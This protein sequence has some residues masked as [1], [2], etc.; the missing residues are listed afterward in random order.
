[1]IATPTES[2]KAPNPPQGIAI[3]G[4]VF[5][6]L[7]VSS[8]ILPRRAVPADSAEIGDWLADR[9]LR[10]WVHIALNLLPFAEIAFLWF[11]R[12]LRNR[13]GL[14]EDRF[15]ATVFLGSGLLFVAMLFNAASVSRG[16]LDTFDTGLSATYWNMS[17]RNW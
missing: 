6:A 4:V 7:Y 12:V 9:D 16:L 10:N 11:M 13:I 5:S 14:L 3:C 17:F 8:L 15:F 1:M 2:L